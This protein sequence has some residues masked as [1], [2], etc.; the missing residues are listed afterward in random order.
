MPEIFQ[1]LTVADLLVDF[2]TVPV[3]TFTEVT[4]VIAKADA[5]PTLTAP[6]APTYVRGVCLTTKVICSLQ[7]VDIIGQLAITLQ[8]EIRAITAAQTDAI[9]SS[10]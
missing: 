4:V 7:G 6:I 10:K 1:V 8:A 9:H 5:L 3:I 2:G